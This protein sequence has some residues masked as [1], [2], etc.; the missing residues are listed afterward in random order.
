MKQIYISIFFIIS[1]VNFSNAQNEFITT[2]QTTTANESITIPTTGNGYNYTVDWGDGT[3]ENT[4][5]GDA[6]H[7]YATADTYTVEITGDFPRIYFNNL[8]D[9]DKIISVNQW[10]AIEWASMESAF[11]GC[12]NLTIDASDTP[13][14]TNS[15]ILR[16]MFKGATNLV[17]IQETLPIWNVSTIIDFGQMFMNT[18][19]FN[20][21]L[22]SWSFNVA[23]DFSEMF[24]GAKVFNQSLGNPFKAKTFEGM[25]RDAVAFNQPLFWYTP[26]VVSLKNM[27]NGATSFDQNLGSFTINSVTDMTG[28]YTNAGLS[29]QNY[30]QTLSGWF[31]ERNVNDT[32]PNNIT[33]DAGSSQYCLAGDIIEKLTNDHGWQITDSGPGCNESDVFVMT[34]D[35]TS[36][37]RFTMPTSGNGYE[38]TLSLSN[39]EIFYVTSDA[40][41]LFYAEN[42]GMLTVRIYGDFPRFDFDAPSV[43]KEKL[44][45]IEQWG[46][47]QLSEANGAF[48][49]CTNLVL[50]AMDTPD[51]SQIQFMDRMFES[52]SSFVDNGGEM[53]NWD[54]STVTSMTGLFEGSAFNENINDWDV[55]KVEDFSSMFKNN[56]S[57][58]QPLNNWNTEKANDLTNMFDGATAFNQPIGMWNTALAQFF[59][60]MFLNA[61]T[62][63]QNLGNWDISNTDRDSMDGML[64]GSAMSQTNYDATLIGWATLESGEIQIPTNVKL[65]ADTFYCLSEAARNMLTSAPYNWTINDLG[66]S[67]P[68]DFFITTWQTTTTN[69]SITIPTNGSGYNYIVDWGDG[70]IEN[71]FTGNA[72]HEY[73]T[74]GTYTVQITG[75]FPR[76][77][78]NGNSSNGSKILTIEQWGVQQWTSMSDAFEGCSNLKLNAD[79]IPD[80]SQVTSMRRMFRDCSA[81]EDLKDTIGNWDMTPIETIS[82]MFQACTIFNEN[83]GGWTFTVLDNVND[84]FQDATSFNQNIANWDVSKVTEFTEMFQGAT[85]FNQPI[86]SWTLGTVDYLEAMF[87][88]ATAFNQDLSTW[89][90]SNTYDIRNMFDGAISFDQ[91]LSAWDIS[92]VEALNNFFRGSGMSQENYDNTLIRWATLEAGETTIPVDLTLN[93]DIAHC[94]S[95]DA[96]TTLTSA[97]Y[98]W[99]INDLGNACP[100]DAFITTWQTIADNESITIPTNGTGYDYIVD[101]GDGTIE[102]AFTGDATHSYTTAG[103]YEVKITGKFP[104]IY[105]NN[106][107]DKD[108]ILAIEQWGT[109]QWASM[110]AAFYGCTKLVL[111]ALDI[112]DLSLVTTMTFIFQNTT[113]FIDNGGEI[114]NWNTGTVEFLG[115]AF[116]SS[117]FNHDINN[118]DVSKVKSFANMFRNATSFNQPLNNWGLTSATILQNMFNGATSFDQDLGNWDLSNIGSSISISGLLNN[119]GMS[120]SNYDATLIG[121]ATLDAGET[122][123]P[124]GMSL[125]AMGITYCLGETARNVLTSAPYNW[126][127][128]D[129]GLGCQATD[130]FITTWQTTADNQSIR[131]PTRS[132]V[133]YDYHVDWGDGTL[134]F[135]QTNTANHEYATAGTYT[136]KIYGDF[137]QPYFDNAGTSIKPRLQTIEQWGTQQWISMVSGFEDCPNLKLNAD[138]NPDFS[139]LTSL[140]DMFRK[141]TNFED[142]KD[143]IGTWD[144]S[145]VERIDDMFAYCTLFN[146]DISGWTFNNLKD[147]SY[148]FEN[149]TTFNQNLSNWDVSKVENFESM[150]EGAAAFDQPIGIWTIG[151]VEYMISMFKNATAF[152]Q[153]LSGWNMSN[154]EDLED[155]FEGASNFDQNL[156]GWDIS[157]VRFM[158]EMFIGAGMSQA[159][160]DATLIGW[161]TI[162]AGEIQIPADID[163]RA[164]ATYCLAEA[165]RNTLTSA[166]YNWDINDGGLNCD[167]TPPM[168]TLIG[169]NPQ[170]IVLGDGYTELGATTDDGSHVII[171]DS[172]FMDVEGTYTIYYNATDAAGNVATEVTRTVNVVL[173]LSVEDRE[174][175]QVIITPN[176]AN[177]YVQISGLSDSVDVNI[178]TINGVRLK[179]I[180]VTKVNRIDI[181]E[182]TSGIYFVKVISGRSDKTFKLIKN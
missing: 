50:N 20:T 105:F 57:F 32:R 69:E 84:T 4:I 9:K 155:M 12:T 128:T 44:V 52:T 148:V 7:M 24:R 49:G 150:F 146:E 31:L 176:P 70:T 22:I 162:E 141:C 19:K 74:T 86:G 172:E 174:L 60:F 6:T 133:S 117:S 139:Q 36:E 179:Q 143:N 130:A 1:F 16:A 165:A 104:S 181:R 91:D 140:E 73:A 17:D 81:F 123:I 89:D 51:L 80:L 45:S 40:V 96:V 37:N 47:L 182:L 129:A 88:D 177:D 38:Y 18:D 68:E 119:A 27:F 53:N 48:E 167:N 166:P 135:N 99:I 134:S 109:Q 76:I 87:R 102:V 39:G 21:S 13:D 85:S 90:L 63:D 125:G 159:N 82:G 67:C 151:T 163:L 98:N 95:V 35:L 145:D 26:D 112:P 3:I 160:Y 72:T 54:V 61:S 118:W 33:F 127:I 2:W 156:G 75:D 111:N 169:D 78:F 65:D 25:F 152:N 149:A 144:V 5:T 157:N 154:V 66:N 62:F 161:A 43:D 41:Q 132:S 168:I 113:S 131:I 116:N 120:T 11:Y 126:N 100:G 55:S 59:D 101:W 180:S 115:S 23:E 164:N 92:K 30:D 64:T 178:Y 28:M 173:V 124:T 8:G 79:D 83:I 106:T 15:T 103:N 56:T 158:D 97:P 14:L 153:D 170:E 10:G 137:P 107:G 147:C 108:K 46:S 94:L 138:D 175:D 58:N 122:Q 121:W 34:W 114:G 77:Y 142:L 71:G 29:T 93:A 42:I 136:V 110:S 171:D